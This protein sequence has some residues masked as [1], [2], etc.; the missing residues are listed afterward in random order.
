MYFRRYQR[1][2]SLFSR[3]IR[4]SQRQKKI[5]FLRS[6]CVVVI[7]VGIICI[8]TYKVFPALSD[9]SRAYLGNA[10]Y[11]EVNNS[12]YDYSAN[13]GYEE[14]IK[15]SY[16]TDGKVSSVNTN[17]TSINITRTTISKDILTKIKNGDISTIHLPIGCLFDSSF[18][19]AKG[20]KLSFKVVG[21]NSFLSSVESDF[22]E[23][24]INQTL[25]RIYLVFSV[26]LKVSLPLHT[27]SVPVKCKYLIA[28]TVIVGDIPDAYTNISRFFDDISESEIDDIN[29]FG[30]E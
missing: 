17:V 9:S 19:Y 3:K 27:I 13:N 24:G 12:I 22:T 23:S 29:D 21:S 16:G 26:N 4:L 20:P 5:F 11:E 7:V 15:I 25:H 10:I 14:Y 28:E 8:Y 18:L 6:L 1:L 30:A 2:R